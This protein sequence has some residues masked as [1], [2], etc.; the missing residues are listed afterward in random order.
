MQKWLKAAKEAT[1][2]F[3]S[4]YM[5]AISFRAISFSATVFCGNDEEVVWV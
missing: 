5:R 1:K 2:K 4:V 3:Y